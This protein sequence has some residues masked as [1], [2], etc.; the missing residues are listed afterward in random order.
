VVLFEEIVY[1]L[2]IVIDC[3]QQ[4]QWDV[5]ILTEK[6]DLLE[7]AKLAEEIS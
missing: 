5:L 4:A 7:A 6:Q 1:V 3:D 2:E